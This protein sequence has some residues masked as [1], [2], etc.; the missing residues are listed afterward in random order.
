LKGKQKTITEQLLKKLE[1]SAEFRE[2]VDSIMNGQIILFIKHG[3][4]NTRRFID[5]ENFNV[6]EG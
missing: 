6:G 4:I 1:T 3:K 5:D 2:K